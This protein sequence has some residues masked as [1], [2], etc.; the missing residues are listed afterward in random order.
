YRIYFPDNVGDILAAAWRRGANA[1]IAEYREKK[2]IRPTH[3]EGNGVHYL[4]PIAANGADV[5]EHKNLIS[6]AA[7]NI[8]HFGWGIDMV[9]ADASVITDDVADA[10][11]GERWLPAENSG[12]LG[13]RVPIE[14]TFSDL[15]R[16]HDA[17]V[18][19]IAFHEARRFS[20]K[21]VPP[22]SAFRIA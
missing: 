1:D 18:N 9:A 15:M 22:L 5:A 4:F 19:R 7:R 8:T 14:G 12:A 20:S 16:K 11:M 10:L 2:D 17:F 6:T 3:L 21:P 13:L